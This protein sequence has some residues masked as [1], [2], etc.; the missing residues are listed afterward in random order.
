MG[1]ISRHD[2]LAG[3]TYSVNYP[4]WPAHAFCITHLWSLS[5]E[6]QF[7]LL[8]PSVMKLAG[9]TRAMVCA[10]VVVFL[11][12]LLRSGI[13]LFFP[14]SY[15]DYIGNTF[16]TTADAIACGCLLAAVHKTLGAS[17]RYRSILASN[18]M[19]LLP[20]AVVALN[21]CSRHPRFAFLVGYSTIN[22]LIA[23]YIHHLVLKPYGLIGWLLNSG[24]M[25]WLGTLSYSIYLWQQVFLNPDWSSILTSFPWNIGAAILAACVSY[26]LVER[27]AFWFR[28]HVR[29]VAW[30]QYRLQPS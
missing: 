14:H 17:P 15:S 30:R 7:Y 21:A 20:I 26:Y 2:M 23:F 27:W 25:V 11:S 18:W 5:V 3:L 12:P 10:A 24:P 4:F 29:P 28:D 8:W 6:E 9:I 1:A 19:H 22:L 13:F 16:E